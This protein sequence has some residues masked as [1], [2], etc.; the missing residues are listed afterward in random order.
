MT[1]SYTIYWGGGLFDQKELMGNLLLAQ[2]VQD[3]SAGKY[4]IRLPQNGDAELSRDA[5]AIRNADL[6]A[7]LTADL[8]L[9]NFDGTDL[10]SGTVIEFCVAKALDIPTVLLRTDF[11]NAGDSKDVPW[12]LMTAGWQRTKNLWLPA[13]AGYQHYVVKAEDKIA[14]VQAWNHDTALRIVEALDTVCC[15]PAWLKADEAFSQ[16]RRMVLSAGGQLDRLLTD[17][18]LRDIIHRKSGKGLFA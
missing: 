12:N 5:I 7:L 14:A 3:T 6:Q 1:S 15:M 8:L 4:Q 16:Y 2:A 10:D 17:D 13:L 9:A 11:R 18:V